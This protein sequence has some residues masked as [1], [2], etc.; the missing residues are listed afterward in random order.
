M[1]VTG[2][3]DAKQF[4]QCGAC[5]EPDAGGLYMMAIAK[6]NC[7]DAIIAAPRGRRYREVSEQVFEVLESYTP[8]IQPLSIDEA[9]L[10]VTGSRRLHGSPRQIAVSIRKRIVEVS[11]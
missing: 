3:G 5:H 8:L 6:R 10:D 7:P 1:A 9:F 4:L 11:P 2:R